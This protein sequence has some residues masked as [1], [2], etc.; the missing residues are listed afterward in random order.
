MDKIIEK[1]RTKMLCSYR[2]PET[3]TETHT[4]TIDK[5]K[6]IHN[7]ANVRKMNK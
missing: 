1:T 7:D 5:K 2:F 6:T 4:L 3:D